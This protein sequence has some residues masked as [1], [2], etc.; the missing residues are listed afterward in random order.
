MNIDSEKKDMLRKS[1]G[2]AGMKGRKD[3]S[4]VISQIMRR[5]EQILSELN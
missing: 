2:R 4:Q 1:I 5:N 3:K